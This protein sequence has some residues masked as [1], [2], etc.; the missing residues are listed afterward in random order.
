MGKTNFDVVVANQLIGGTMSEVSPFAKVLY[1]DGTNGSDTN[2][3]QQP[4]R[5]FATIAQAISLSTSGAGDHIV[6]APG[7]YTIT[8]ALVPKARNVFRA[9]V[10]TPR[11][12]SVIITG[13]IADLIQLDVDGVVFYGIEIK[14][15]GNTA[16]NLVDIADTTAV[17]GV[18]FDS[19]TF[20]GDDK[21]SVDAINAADATNA[22]TGLVVRNC[23]F[24]DLTGTPIDIGV[25][26]MPYG[27]IGYN[28]FAID[29]NSGTGINLADTSAFATGKGYVI[30]HN[31]FTGFDATAD[32]VGITIAGTEDTTG[33][34][35]IRNN[36][37]AYMAAAAIT[38][39]KLSKSEVNN[40]YGDAAT[41]GTLV[42][43]GT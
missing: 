5:A 7:T 22:V 18:V 27:Y 24:R 33:A 11:V 16:D 40:Y 43:P 3:G 10:V 41:G 34:G 32:E 1:V 25:Q 21:T 6:I 14:A 38:I 4:D 2:N 20:N 42:D 39:D 35:I 29:V 13:N 12:P 23:L 8:S 30:E 36:Y 28:H 17:S 31:V 26:G 15:S 37:F 19:C 9:A